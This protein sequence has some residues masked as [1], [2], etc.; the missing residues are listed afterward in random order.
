[1]VLCSTLGTLEDMKV[2]PTKSRRVTDVG[3]TQVKRG[4]S[5]LYV[6]VE[7]QGNLT[8]MARVYSSV[9]PACARCER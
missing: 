3:N 6:K 2:Q 4:D 7:T 9:V 8:N 5:F 1:M